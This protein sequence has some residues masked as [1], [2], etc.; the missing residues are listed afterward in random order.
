M[1]IRLLQI[2]IPP[3][4]AQRRYRA[5]EPSAPHAGRAAAKA[6]APPAIPSH[7]EYYP[8]EHALALFRF[9]RFLIICSSNGTIIAAP[10]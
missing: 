10:K 4:Q 7:H 3:L 9:L 6:S 2:I 5:A 8:R 1:F